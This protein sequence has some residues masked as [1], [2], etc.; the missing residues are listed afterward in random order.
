MKK[1]IL[2]KDVDWNEKGIKDE[3]ALQAINKIPIQLPVIS[4]DLCNMSCFLKNKEW[5]FGSGGIKFVETTPE[6]HMFIEDIYKQITDKYLKIIKSGNG[7]NP[8][9]ID[10]VPTF[11]DAVKFLREHAFFNENDLEKFVIQFIRNQKKELNS[12][13]SVMSIM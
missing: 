12:D 1:D 7:N 8:S 3:G 13:S 11:R 5:E 6:D 2:N 4:I 10:T 9:K